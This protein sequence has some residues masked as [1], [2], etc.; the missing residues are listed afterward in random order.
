MSVEP[1]LNPSV[2]LGHVLRF[3]ELLQPMLKLEPPMFLKILVFLEPEEMLHP[4]L[5]LF[6][7]IH[8]GQRHLLMMGK[9]SEN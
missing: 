9:S 5:K 7:L 1:I 6:P 4:V 3:L 8:G 2:P